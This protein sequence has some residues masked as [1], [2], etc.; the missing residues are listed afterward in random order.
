MVLRGV[1]C[2]LTEMTNGKGLRLS[3]VHGGDTYQEG[4]I[5]K[6]LNPQVA[7]CP[8]GL[9]QLQIQRRTGVKFCAGDPQAKAST[10][11][12]PGL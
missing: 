5:S 7:S 11:A 8:T 12:C 4:E 2:Q 9:C 10:A 1:A 6:C 3:L